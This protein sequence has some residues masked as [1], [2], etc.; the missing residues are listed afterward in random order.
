MVPH[1][2]TVFLYGPPC[3]RNFHSE[4]PRGAPEHRDCASQ[5]R[6]ATRLACSIA[7]CEVD[8]AHKKRGANASRSHVTGTFGT[9][10]ATEQHKTC[11]RRMTNLGVSGDLAR[12]RAQAT[13]SVNA[14]L[15]ELH[16]SV[17][18]IQSRS[19][20]RA[21]IGARHGQVWE[22]TE[23]KST[24]IINAGEQIVI[25]QHKLGS[26]FLSTASGAV[27]DCAEPADSTLP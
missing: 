22:Q 11:L 18:G 23:K 1:Q 16:A 26:F 2:E 9:D 24:F 20:W 12:K 4:C 27:C 15:Q 19:L 14:P 21:R 3:A 5:K 25:N 7:R 13:K 17:T 6:D 8:T 10:V